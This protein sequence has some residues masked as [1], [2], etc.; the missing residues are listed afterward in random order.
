MKRFVFLAGLL[1]LVGCK[2]ATDPTP[3]NYLTAINAYLGDHPDCLLDG[4][5]H[6]PYETSDPA[7]TKQMDALTNAGM[8]AVTREPAIHISRYTLTLSAAS[9]TRDLCFGY[10][11]A[12]SVVSSTPP[13]PANG[14]N[15]TK[16]VYKYSL[17]DVHVWAKSQEMT[18]A[19]P[20][21]SKEATGEATDTITLAQN[22]VG[23]AVPD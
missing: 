11:T 20:V 18:D 5:I 15:E 7:K 10:R 21:L 6:F 16:V 22:R 1:L 12:T 17:H 4:S 13:A 2:S 8:L 9:A 14:F 3:E 19:F 23:W